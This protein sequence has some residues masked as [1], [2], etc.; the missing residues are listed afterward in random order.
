MATTVR[1]VA[2]PQ[3]RTAL[4][5]S[6]PRVVLISILLDDD[7][8]LQ[9]NGG[10]G[11][12]VPRQRRLPSVHGPPMAVTMKI[13]KAVMTRAPRRSR[14]LDCVAL[15]LARMTTTMM[16]KRLATASSSEHERR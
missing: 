3:A 16:A 2:A 13:S 7:G 4:S 12:T 15:Q 8:E 5:P 10:D 14:W 9:G 11:V 6:L 1:T